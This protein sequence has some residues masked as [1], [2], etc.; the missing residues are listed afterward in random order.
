MDRLY[1]YTSSVCV[2]VCVEEGAAWLLGPGSLLWV[3]GGGESGGHMQQ[4]SLG[5]VVY[6]APVALCMG[7]SPTL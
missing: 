4:N 5:I 7:P 6:A 2:Y 3:R 1:Q